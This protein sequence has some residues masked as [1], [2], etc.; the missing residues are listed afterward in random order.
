MSPKVDPFE[1]RKSKTGKVRVQIFDANGEVV[2]RAYVENP[3]GSLRKAQLES[4]VAPNA[5]LQGLDLSG[6]IL[7]WAYLDH[8]DLSFANL[9]NADL[10]GAN[11]DRTICRG[12]IFRDANL[13]RNNIGSRTSL[14]GADLSQAVLDGAVLTDAIYDSATQFPV[15][16]DPA[17]H[18]MSHVDDL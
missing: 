12:T 2:Y 15:S 9:S 14:R 7:Y 17:M 8:A 6:A 4:F 18:G 1:P 10:R 3:D 11:L 5:Q 16:F 13:G